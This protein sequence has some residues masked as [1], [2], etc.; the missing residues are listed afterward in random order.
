MKEEVRRR[1]LKSK[2]MSLPADN[3][4]D[5]T[6]L[7]AKQAAKIESLE[8]EIAW[9][10]EQCRLAAH[11]QFGASSEKT[12]LAAQQ[13]MTFDEVEATV[14]P[15]TP[16][17]TVETITYRR[18][19]AHGLR[20]AQL[21]AFPVEIIPHPLTDAQQTCACC[22]GPVHVIRTEVRREVKFTPATV[23]V[24]EHHREVGGC[25]HCQEHE[26][27][28]PIVTAPMP[29]PAFP[30]SLA[31]PSAVAYI[32]SQKYVEGLPLYRQQQAFERL[33]IALSR[34]TLA[35][36][37]LA[38]ADWLRPFYHRLKTFLLA[39]D[40][41][42]ADETTLQVLK[43]PG[44]AAESDSYLWLYR[45]GRDGPPI[46]LF[47]Y[48]ETRAA[49]HPKAFLHGFRGYL[50]VDGYIAYEI[51]PGVRGSWLRAPIACRTSY[52]SAA[53]PTRAVCSR[54]RSK[55]SPPPRAKPTP[56]QRRK[57]D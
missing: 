19:K 37:M 52:W 10:K 56:R 35:N 40:I 8:G 36:W 28:T 12:P 39:R 46:I 17:P 24:V 27:A 33:G 31:S 55:R 5:L 6:V 13:M 15:D 14:S 20:E 48:Q 47:D 16:E 57:S 25:R 21:K 1:A 41:L 9:L 32:M 18:R 54:T 3:P 23:T 26:I 38:G 11:R 42:H 44:R 43:E 22:G 45:T 2:S 34:Q 53:S 7:C 30:K 49:K 51:L 29:A 50:H 4:L